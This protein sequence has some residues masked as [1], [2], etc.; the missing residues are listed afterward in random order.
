MQLHAQRLLGQLQQQLAEAYAQE[1]Q[2]MG[3][4]HREGLAAAVDWRQSQSFQLLAQAQARGSAQQLRALRQALVAHAGD[5]ELLAAPL[6]ALRGDALPPRLELAG[7]AASP[8]HEAQRHE[9]E[10]RRDEQQAARQAS[11]P[12]LSLQAQ[13]QRRLAVAAAAG[14]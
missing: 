7:V 10:A 11:W 5:A 12:V 4:R 14:C 3:V 6:R 13:A 2:R 8:R 9:L 1:A